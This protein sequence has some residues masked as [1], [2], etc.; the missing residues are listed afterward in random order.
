MFRIIKDNLLLKVLLTI[1]VVIVL[2]VGITSYTSSQSILSNS[3]NDVQEQIKNVKKL[4]FY[5]LRTAMDSYDVTKVLGTL[6]DVK[7]MGVAKKLHIVKDE[8]ILNDFKDMYRDAKIDTT[9]MLNDFKNMSEEQKNVWKSQKDLVIFNKNKNGS[10]SAHLIA[11]MVAEQECIACHSTSKVGD[12]MALIEIDFDLHGLDGMLEGI[13]HNIVLS[14]ILSLLAL[15]GI[16]FFLKK[17]I[18]NPLNKLNNAIIDLGTG[19]M[20]VKSRLEITSSDEFGS[21]TK[22]MNIFLENSDNGLTQ[23]LKVISEIDTVLSKVKL[24]FFNFKVHGTAHNK[25]INNVSYTINDMISTLSANLEKINNVAK[26]Y[27]E[28]KFDID[29]PIDPN[30]NGDM[31][32]T[33]QNF[34]LISIGI[35]D[36]MNLISK[37][38]TILFE[39]SNDMTDNSQVQNEMMLRQASNLEEVSAAMEEISG[40][41][42]ENTELSKTM[43]VDSTNALNS[44]K[45][46][47]D[48]STKSVD[49]MLQVLEATEKVQNSVAQIEQIAF[50]TNILSLNAAVEAATA[51]EHGKGFAVVAQEVRNLAARSAEAA[52]E[53]KTLAN[54][55][56]EKVE[57]GQSLSVE[58]SDSFNDVSEK[59][60]K[61]QNNIS[62]VSTALIEQSDGVSQIS[63]TTSS[64][65]QATQETS[66]LSNSINE[67]SIQIL[68]LSNSLSDALSQSQY[69]D[70]SNNNDFDYVA[71]INKNKSNLFVLKQ[72]II[73]N[74]ETPTNIDF[75]N[76][77]FTSFVDEIN[78]N[79]L[80]Y[81][82]KELL[83]KLKSLSTSKDLNSN[84]LSALYTSIEIIENRILSILDNLK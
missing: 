18:L 23:D 31:A 35:S 63:S 81:E 78:N 21:L 27:S 22:N 50:Q 39:S 68:E 58:T 6:K 84:S 77:P 54:I 48:I 25:Q 47:L 9:P 42:K 80:N 28:L 38:Q 13:N 1:T 10:N 44:S 69:N 40:N 52:N 83:S 75:N 41:I 60:E 43:L 33:L 49:V 14:I 15:V 57:E 7:E 79:D 16:F 11:P 45:H 17:L 19:K 59:I 67:K 64:L 51:G 73:K 32:Q 24:G 56:R 4:T 62:F 70:T 30:I 61:T 29:L 66:H 3:K 72:H 26:S 46:G 8:K 37:T 65:D 76:N 82:Y 20:D 36:Y 55:T 74:M 12:T 53:I 2:L 34:R 5:T 71:N